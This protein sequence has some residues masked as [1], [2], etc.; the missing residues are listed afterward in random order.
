ML[1]GFDLDYLSLHGTDFLDYVGFFAKLASR[2]H[3]FHEGFGL[4]HRDVKPGNILNEGG[5][6]RLIDYELCVREGYFP[7]GN[8]TTGTPAYMPIEQICGRLFDQDRRIDVYALGMTMY[9]LIGRHPFW[10]SLASEELTLQRQRVE[11][12]DSLYLVNE[13]VSPELSF[14]VM[15]CLEKNRNQRYGNCDEL[16][17]ALD[18]VV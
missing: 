18:K 12:P 17:E 15:K 13:Q 5:T 3:E 2:L 4:V 8:H 1:F 14:V 11:V 16:A 9:D 10:T 6:P 7:S